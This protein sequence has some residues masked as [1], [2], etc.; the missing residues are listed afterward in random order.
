MRL[1]M[2]SPTKLGKPIVGVFASL[3]EFVRNRPTFASPLEI[4]LKSHL[5]A[6][7]S[8][9]EAHRQAGLEILGCIRHKLDQVEPEDIDSAC[10]KID[11]WL[12]YSLHQL[13]PT[14]HRVLE[15]SRSKAERLE[16]GLYEVSA[17]DDVRKVIKESERIIRRHQQAIEL[18][19][20]G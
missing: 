19:S 2:P 5:L 4:E 6:D 7:P 15:Y 17:I 14:G 3:A 10:A 13:Q 18:S 8:L 1:Q 20:I 11:P 12:R 16:R 9:S